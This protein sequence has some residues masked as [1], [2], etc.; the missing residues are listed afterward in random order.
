MS[1]EAYLEIEEKVFESM[2]KQ[3]KENFKKEFPNDDRVDE[4]YWFGDLEFD[5]DSDEYK[6][7]VLELSGSLN[8]PDS[9]KKLGYISIKMKMDRDRV[10]DII[11]DYSKRL[12]KIKTV[13]EATKGV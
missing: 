9:D 12:G 2:K 4:M 7:G 11:N 3:S 5:C 13:L 1:D 10:I 8:I 6:D